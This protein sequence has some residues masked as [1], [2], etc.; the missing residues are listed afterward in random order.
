[1]IKDTHFGTIPGTKVPSLYKPGAE[2]IMATFRLSAEPEVE[3]LS[4]DDQVRYRV[5]VKILSSS[6]IVVGFGIGEC[7]SNEEKYKWRAAVCPEEFAEAPPTRK[8][9]KWVKGKWDERSR[10]YG[11][12]YK[13]Q[14]VRTEPA[15]LANTIL[16]MA[17][18]RGLIDGVLT[19]TAASDI[20]T[21][22]IEDLPEEYVAAQQ[23]AGAE[24]KAD[25]VPRITHDQVLNLRTA[26]VD[27]GK[28][29]DAFCKKARITTL[30]SLEADR[31]EAA[32]EL[33]GKSA[34]AEKE[35]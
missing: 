23:S 27:A 28:S 3:D 18:K 25:M 30:E 6:G 19:A 13:I 21:Q 31:Y 5:K 11:K 24:N 33:I 35:P 29:E 1:M 26:L 22:D 12:A 2:K 4:D 8:R 7:S 20:F 32:L 14:Q 34:V 15:D 9:E 10:S 17:K 16:K